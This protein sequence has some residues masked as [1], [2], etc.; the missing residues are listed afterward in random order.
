[1]QTK[2]NQFS[3]FHSINSILISIN[4]EREKLRCLY[5]AIAINMVV[6]PAILSA[7]HDSER[8]SGMWRVC[9][10]ANG[11]VDGKNKIFLL[12]K[13]RLISIHDRIMWIY[14]LRFNWHTAHTRKRKP[15]SPSRTGN[16][17]KESV[18][19]CDLL[20][21]GFGMHIFFL[22]LCRLRHF[23]FYW[24]SACNRWTFHRCLSPHFAHQV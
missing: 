1:M 2:R 3:V 7:N 21:D 6:V 14:V 4:E 9:R 18:N 12:N 17:N 5:T 19:L 10:G 15:S 11:R 22:S 24:C 23:F 13:S 16:G 8:E 20:Y